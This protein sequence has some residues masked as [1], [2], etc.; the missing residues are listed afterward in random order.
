MRLQFFALLAAAAL[1][2]AAGS[3][4]ARR[5]EVAPADPGARLTIDGRL[6]THFRAPNGS[7]SARRRADLAAERL[8]EL[9]PDG[10]AAR[11]IE[12]RPRAD[13]AWGV[14]AR[15][16]LLM[17]AT[18][19]EAKLRGESA[20]ETARRWAG[21]LK[22]ALGEGK[23]AARPG[24]P[25]K[26]AAGP[27]VGVPVTDLVVPLG[28]TRVLNVEGTARGELG[29]RV[30]GEAVSAEAAGAQIRVKG[31]APGKAVVRV[32]RDGKETAFTAWVKKYAGVV[33]EVPG[34][35]VTGS[36]APLAYVRK[37]AVERA[38]EGVRREPG[39]T[40]AITGPAEGLRALP[41][42][43]HAI[44]RFPISIRGEGLLENRTYAQVRV[45][46][47]PLRPETARVLLYSNDPESV[48]E[49]G[50]LFEG[51]LDAE[52]P[53]RLMFHH[54]NRMG[55]ACT[56]EVHLLNPGRQAVDV[57][58]VEA[59]AGPVLDT[60]QVGHR[61]AQKYMEAA[62]N[63]VGYVV[64]IPPRK[65][66]TIYG[67]SLPDRLTVSGIYNLRVLDG[68]PLI[69]HVSAAPQPTQ[70]EVTDDLLDAAR[71]EP[72]TY[73]SPQKDEAYQY[74]VGGAWTFIPMGRK[75]I[76]AR[77][78]NRRLFGNYGVI[79]NLTV[80]LT[81]PTD[82]E[83]TVT[84][85]LA[86]EAGWTRGVFVIDGRVIEAPQIAPPA[87]ATLWSTRLAPQESRK[88]RIQGIPVGGSS[89][90]VSLVVRP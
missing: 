28:E 1:L 56:F 8:R 67:V 14:F 45:D 21:N 68:G 44:V 79:Y 52:G 53:A 61:A 10:L 31:L 48:R 90:P 18:E 25:A 70:P 26:P 5:V 82:E 51:V 65:S 43:E 20:A 78:P 41:R 69:A 71:A 64:T 15:G 87:E 62:L 80:D 9:I 37:V 13:G 75:A 46:N 24:R 84:V 50:T 59:D 27:T 38:L 60:I 35:M 16:G 33:A 83:K 77:T 88:V 39:A 86:A 6:I 57:Q 23:A 49:Y 55:R 74:R 2:P 47:L 40:V 85:R 73:P 58:V 72:D 34:G 22:A 36:V 81:N 3:L 76:T 7:L 63:D 89:Y 30:E 19:A 54:Q 66:R 29:L 17:I 42:G 32:A 11:D 4:A 12:A